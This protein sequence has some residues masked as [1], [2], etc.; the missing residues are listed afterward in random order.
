MT[1]YHTDANINFTVNSIL[2]SDELLAKFLN[3]DMLVNDNWINAIKCVF[4][5]SQSQAKIASKIVF[6]KFYYK[7]WA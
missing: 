7:E 4:N 6:K 3:A 2:N 5:L 1:K